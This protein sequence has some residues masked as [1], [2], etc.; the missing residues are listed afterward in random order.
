[1][2]CVAQWMSVFSTRYGL[3]DKEN[4]CLVILLVGI[5][6]SLLLEHLVGY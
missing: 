5:T 6:G 3:H 4:D 1:M 2:G